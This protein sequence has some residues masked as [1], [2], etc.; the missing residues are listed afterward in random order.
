[1]LSTPARDRGI[2]CIP[3]CHLFRQKAPCTRNNGQRRSLRTRLLLV[4]SPA[5]R[6]Q[7][8]SRPKG[9]LRPSRTFPGT[10]GYHLSAG[11]RRRI[12]WTLRMHLLFATNPAGAVHQDFL[13]LKRFNI[14]LD[15][16][17][18]LAEKNLVFGFI[19]P[20]KF[21]IICSW[22]LRTSRTT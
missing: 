17:G 4:A 13:V 2:Q 6:T 16:R 21:P 18:P 8:S 10:C 12:L 20:L 3:C 11:T 14:L 7:S 15:V 5:C 9:R 1:M 19:L 22:L